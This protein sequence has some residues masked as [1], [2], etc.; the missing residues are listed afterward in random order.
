MRTPPR[1]PKSKQIILRVCTTNAE[2]QCT[3]SQKQSQ[4]PYILGKSPKRAREKLG[5]DEVEQMGILQWHRK[6]NP[7][8]SLQKRASQ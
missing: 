5:E 1:I 4:G 2:P 6:Y 8:E 7:Q 3:V